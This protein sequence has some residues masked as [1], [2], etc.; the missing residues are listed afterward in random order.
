MSG[1]AWSVGILSEMTAMMSSIPGE[2]CGLEDDALL[3][4]FVKERSSAA[5]EQ[6]VHRHVRAVYSAALR[7]VQDAALAEDVTQGVFMV[8]TQKAPTVQHMKTIGGWLLK[9]TRYCAIDARRKEQRQRRHEQLA[10]AQRCEAETGAPH[11]SSDEWERLW[12]VLDEALSSLRSIDRDALYLRYFQAQ[13]FAAIGAKLGTNEEAARKRVS[14]ALEKLRSA[15]SSRGTAISAPS[16]AT[17]VATHAT[18]AALPPALIA[19]IITG[20]T[21]TVASAGIGLSIAKGALHIMAWTK[22]QTVALAAAAVVLF[23]GGGAAIVAT[24][25]SSGRIAASAPSTTIAVSTA[26]SQRD[27][28]LRRQADEA[29]RQADEMRR[30]ADAARRQAESERRDIEQLRTQMDQVVATLEKLGNGI[31]AF[32][33]DTGRFPTTE[34]GLNA[35]IQKPAGLGSWKGPYAR[36]IPVD[37][38]G[39]S[40]H[41]VQPGVH[42]IEGY[43]LWSSG[44][45][46]ANDSENQLGNW[47]R[48]R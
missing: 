28:E 22:A 15:I 2:I 43:D 36:E 31:A 19:T 3:R 1:L 18:A 42:N 13:S 46:G 6:L 10:A 38:W 41:Y 35:L 23:V 27:D 40:F 17:A 24:T 29:R 12:P 16:I 25:N 8:L 30:Q 9:V 47:D 5:F 32:K 20:A 21:T 44:P 11:S 37:P 39:Q 26:D 33:L 4:Q 48:R 45:K 7:Q 14:R 34:E